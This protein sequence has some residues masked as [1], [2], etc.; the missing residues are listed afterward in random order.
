MIAL[1]LTRSYVRTPN[2]VLLKRSIHAG[3]T[4]LT[5][6]ACPTRTHTS[7]SIL[8]DFAIAFKLSLVREIQPTLTLLSLLNPSKYKAPSLTGLLTSPVMDCKGECNGH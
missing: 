1:N 6:F 5:G 7:D 3:L 2:P 8:C 4:G